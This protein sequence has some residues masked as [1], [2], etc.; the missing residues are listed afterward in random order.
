MGAARERLWEFLFPPDSGHWLSILRIGLGLQVI[1][2]ACSLRTDWNDLFAAHGPVLINRTLSEAI[3][4]S[5]TLLTPRLGWLIAAGQS[6]GLTE[7]T[8]LSLLW[9]GL[10]SAGLLLLSGLG[11]RFAAIAAWILHLCSVKS[12]LLFSYGVDN[13][14]TIGLFYLMIA[15]LPDALALDWRLRRNLMVSPQRLG[16]HRRVLQLHLSVI[17]FFGGFSKGLGIGWWNGDSMWRSLSRPPFD[18]I[19]PDALIRFASLLAPIG[20]L[21]CLLELGYPAF[22][23]WKQT[24][25]FWLLAIVLMHLSTGV[26]MGLQLFALIMIVLNLA[27]FGPEYLLHRTMILL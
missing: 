25:F 17:Y 4:S 16:F 12:G 14:T 22:I 24:R 1:L 15:P 5:N 8:T 3:L 20:I 11:C 9:L 13:F 26:T 6:C 18:L 2:Y 19:S 23:W 27:A 7:P 21:V 10:V